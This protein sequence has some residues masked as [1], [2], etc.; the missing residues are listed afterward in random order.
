MYPKLFPL[1]LRCSNGRLALLSEKNAIEAFAYNIGF[2]RFHQRHHWR[3]QLLEVSSAV[4]RLQHRVE[5]WLFYRSAFSTV[6][7]HTQPHRKTVELQT[8]SILKALIHR[9]AL[10]QQ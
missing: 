4:P 3:L 1:Q 9:A 6:L 7:V 8:I 2:C 5:L 10:I